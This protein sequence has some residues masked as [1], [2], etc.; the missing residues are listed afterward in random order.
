MEPGDVL[1]HEFM[2]VVDELG[3]DVKNVKKGDRAVA[4]F[5]IACGQCFYCQ[6]G[7]FSCCT[8][9][10]PSN[11][12]CPLYGHKTGGFFG[13]HASSLCHAV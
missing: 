12:L 6:K 7:L 1:G 5:D 3:S 13:A 11:M 2:G 9:T 4:C 10:N 8:K